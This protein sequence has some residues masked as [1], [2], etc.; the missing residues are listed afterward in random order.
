M[1]SKQQ[2]LPI[3]KFIGKSGKIVKSRYFL[4]KIFETGNAFCRFGVIISSK[5][6]KR[7]VD[8][9]RLKR[10]IFNF[11][12]I[13]GHALPIADYLLIVSVNAV[14]LGKEELKNELSK[15]L[16]TNN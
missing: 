11:F 9:N 4:L 7:A 12:R 8:R 14:K 10:Q 3:Q 5:V 1:L 2:R 15:L 13:A 16:T 6:A